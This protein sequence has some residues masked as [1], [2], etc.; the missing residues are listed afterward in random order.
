VVHEVVGQCVRVH[1]VTSSI[2]ASVR[3]S[4]LYVPLDEWG[5][6]GLS[7]PCMVDRRIVDLE[8]G[9]IMSVAGCLGAR[10]YGRLFSG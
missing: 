9:D 7:R 4:Q 3:Q 8:L 6:A 5:T 1:P 2:K 10:D